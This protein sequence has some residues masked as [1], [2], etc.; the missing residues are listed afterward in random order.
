MQLF[1]N[2][3]ALDMGLPVFRPRLKRI[4]SPSRRRFLWGSSS[5]L[6]LVGGLAIETSAVWLF[7]VADGRAHHGGGFP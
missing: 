3:N 1:Q 7:V 5:N 2:G 6:M 4:G